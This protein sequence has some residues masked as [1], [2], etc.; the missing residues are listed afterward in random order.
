MKKLQSSLLFIAALCLTLSMSSCKGECDDVL[1]QNGGTCVDGTCDC[2]EGFSGTNCEIDLCAG[3]TCENGGTCLNGSC[4]C[5]TGYLGSTC[6]EFDPT[7]VQALLA[8]HTPIELVNGG[9][10]LSSLYG[11][12]YEG[13]L[14]FYLNTDDGTGMVAALEDQNP[15]T[16]WGCQGTDIM[17]LNNVQG[18]PTNPEI[19]EG[20]RIGDGKDNTDAILAECIFTN[21][22]QLCR[23][24]GEDWFLPS[25]GELELMATNLPASG[26][27]ALAPFA[28]WSSTEIDLDQVWIHFIDT[29]FPS[30]FSKSNGARVRAAKSF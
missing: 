16:A 18:P 30:E 7:Q 5:P 9:I 10:P 27:N 28:Y 23:E 19:E 3:L 25:R 6:E 22:A 2:P 26:H 8:N 21:A 14:I 20:A 24:L 17:G 29:D 12:M 4:D 11:K 15:G 1:C 13:G